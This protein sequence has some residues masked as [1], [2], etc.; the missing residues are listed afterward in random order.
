MIPIQY[1]LVSSQKTNKLFL[2]VSFFS[3]HS[4]LFFLF[5]C[6]SNHKKITCITTFKYIQVY[7][8]ILGDICNVMTSYSQLVILQYFFFVFACNF[9]YFDQHSYCT[10]VLRSFKQKLDT[11]NRTE[12]VI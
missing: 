11:V 1:M 3:L 6:R 8:Y 7:T 5:E 9:F 4:T 2:A 12:N 10:F